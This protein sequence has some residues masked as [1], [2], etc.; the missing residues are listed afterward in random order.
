MKYQAYALLAVT[1]FSAGCLS[2]PVG[3]LGDEGVQP[4]SLAEIVRDSEA[5]VVAEYTNLINKGEVT[6]V[7]VDTPTPPGT[8]NLPDFTMN[9]LLT[10]L[11]VESVLKSDGSVT[12]TA[13]IS[14]TMGGVVPV[15]SA[16]HDADADSMWPHVWPVRT[17]FI[18]FVKKTA[19]ANTYAVP[20][21]ECGRVLTG[22]TEVT[23]SDGDRTVLSYMEGLDRDEFI[24]AIQ[25]E[26]AN[27]NPTETPYPWPTHSPE[28]PEPTP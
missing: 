28:P 2:R 27:P 18:L 5:I 10:E 4:E 26:V 14:Y 3:D 7:V 12:T 23:C 20:W 17:E 6:L 11:S 19:G 21:G 9:V 8:Q 22:G 1:I 15:G 24:S 25:T 16:A 13:P